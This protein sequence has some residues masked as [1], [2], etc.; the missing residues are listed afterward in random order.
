VLVEVT[1][2]SKGENS[3]VQSTSKNLASGG[4][5]AGGGGKDGIPGMRGMCVGT[6]YAHSSKDS[7]ARVRTH[8]LSRFLMCC[9]VQQTYTP[10]LRRDYTRICRACFLGGGGDCGS[11]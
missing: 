11:R 4:E 9:V 1:V 2:N 3:F 10:Q 7:T 6:G 8:N 5:G